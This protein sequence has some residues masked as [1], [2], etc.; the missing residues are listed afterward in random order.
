MISSYEIGFK[1]LEVH[2]Q[3][4]VPTWQAVPQNLPT[5]QSEELVFPNNL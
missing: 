1:Y 3:E 2:Q 5:H 4:G